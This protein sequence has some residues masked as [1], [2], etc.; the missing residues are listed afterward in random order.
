MPAAVGSSHLSPITPIPYDATNSKLNSFSPST[1]GLHRPEH[2]LQ[3]I[4][5]MLSKKKLQPT[6]PYSFP[7]VHLDY[8]KLFTAFTINVFVSLQMDRIWNSPIQTLNPYL[9]R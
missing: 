1:P 3:A 5:V 8:C 7:K 6:T 9:V 4:S 2:E